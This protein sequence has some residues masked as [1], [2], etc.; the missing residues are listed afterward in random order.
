MIVGKATT[1]NRQT[2]TLVAVL[3]IIAV[4][5]PARA[6]IHETSV[7]KVPQDIVYKGSPGAPQHA[8]LFGDS[9]QPGLY[10]DRIRFLPGMKVMPHWHPDTVRTVLVMSGTFYFAVGDQWDESKLKAYPA[11]TLY[12]EPP[13]TPHYAWAKDGEVILQITAIGPTGNVPV[14]PKK[15]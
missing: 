1:M 5:A 10:V 4:W 9:S 14:S 6:Q 7:V 8:T 13:R 15:P 3:C 11:G 12:S 2:V